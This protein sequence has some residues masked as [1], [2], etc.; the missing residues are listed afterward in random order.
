MRPW[1]TGGLGNPLTRSIMYVYAL[2]W[3]TYNWGVTIWLW[4]NLGGTL[5]TFPVVLC[6]CVCVCMDWFWLKTTLVLNSFQFR[7]MP[8]VSLEFAQDLLDRHVRTVSFGREI[9]HHSYRWFLLKIFLVI[10]SFKMLWTVTEFFPRHCLWL[11][12][13]IT[14]WWLPSAK[15]RI[16]KMLSSQVRDQCRVIL[17]LFRC[18]LPRR[19]YVTP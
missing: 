9:H 7:V 17:T 15:N 14:R 4:K 10:K 11:K 1:F 3:R 5:L 18:D 12:S 6:V 8:F 2:N 19:H 16:H 13:C